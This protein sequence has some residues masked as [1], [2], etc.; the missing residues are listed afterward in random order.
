M[1]PSRSGILTEA[2]YRKILTKNNPDFP[3]SHLIPH[4]PTLIPRIPTL[5]PCVP[6][7]ISL[8]SFPDSP[9]QFLQIAIIKEEGNYIFVNFT[10]DYTLSW[11]WCLHDLVLSSLLFEQKNKGWDCVEKVLET[12]L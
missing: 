1:L 9:F 11:H 12:K 7:L 8:I 6:T 3:D 5:I 2:I 10:N 4:I